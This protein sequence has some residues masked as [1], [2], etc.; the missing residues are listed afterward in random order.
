MKKHYIRDLI[1]LVVLFVIDRVTKYIVAANLKGQPMLVLWPTKNPDKN[2]LVLRYLENTGSAFSMLSGQRWLLLAVTVVALVAIIW[3]YMK[4]KEGKGATLWQLTL[5]VLAAGALGNMVDRI[6]WGY[7]IDFIYV[8]IIN[9]ATFNFAD[10]CITVSMV[11]LI[12][13][14]LKSDD[15]KKDA[16]KE[17][18]DEITEAEA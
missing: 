15:G 11:V 2:V 4:V 6:R 9:F 7:V 13:L 17:T 12:V 18:E 14:I 8:Q 16:K 10:M 1:I 3:F 5:T